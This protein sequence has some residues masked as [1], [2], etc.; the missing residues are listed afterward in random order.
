MHVNQHTFQSG[1]I[2][3]VVYLNLHYFKA[4]TSCRKQIMFKQ[5]IEKYKISPCNTANCP[6]P[7]YNYSIICLERSKD[8]EASIR[9]LNSSVTSKIGRSKVHEFLF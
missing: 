8:Y 4:S 7:K 6:D 5:R 1:D 3:I 2:S 9:F